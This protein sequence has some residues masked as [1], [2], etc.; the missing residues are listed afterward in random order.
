MSFSH[1][2]PGRAAVCRALACGLLVLSF[3][4]TS[5]IHGSAATRKPNIVV[6][7][8]DDMGWMD[9]GA[10]GSKYYE[11]PNIDR[12]ARRGM[13]FTDAYSANPLCS[14]TRASILTGKYPARHGITTPSGHLPPQ[15]PGYVFMRDRAPP[16]QP[17]LEPESKHYLD[18]AEYTIAEALRDAGY[19]TAHFGK[20][21]LGLTAPY[22]PDK[23]GFDVAWH[24]K[25]DP[26]PP[27]YFSPY[28]FKQY[29]SFA[30][31]P[32]GEYITDRL[33]TEALKFIEANHERP[34]LLHIW[35]YGVH[36]P[37][38]HKEEYT[39][40][41]ADK[42]DARGKQ[43]NPIMASMLKSVDESMGRLLTKLDELKLTDETIILFTSDNG[44]NVHSNTEDD[45]GT[46]RLPPA[47]T[48]KLADWRHWAG[49]Q[50]PTNNAPLRSGKG[51]LYEGGV[52]IPLVVA[53]PGV[54]KVG[55]T[56]S[57]PVSSIDFYPTML[58]MTG[59]VRRPEQVIDGVSLAPLLAG[60]S[61]FKRNALF[62]Y[63]PHSAGNKPAGVT[64][65]RGDWKLIRWWN[66]NSMFPD[67]LE[68][69]NLRDDIGETSN[70]SAKFPELVEE[71]DALIDGFLNSTGATYPKPNPAYNPSAAKRDASLQGW[72]A[73]QC[74]ATVANGVLRVEAI[75][76][77][78]FLGNAQFS[79][80]GPVL[81]KLRARS[82]A[83]GAGKIQ[84]RTTEQEEFPPSGQL[85][86]FELKPG[87]A[88]QDLTV[89]LPVK[90][91]LVHLR[92]YVPA[93]MSPVEIDSLAVLSSDPAS[94]ARQWNFNTPARKQ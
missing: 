19:R 86:A 20:W 13:R 49:N 4:A 16:Q 6:F 87:E 44:G 17:M 40:Q 83:G 2:V 8:V 23:Q 58:E 25:P 56:C 42:R 93:D 76:R 38:G 62:N 82:T 84:W 65:R 15:P 70:L 81:V 72:V 61:G 18:P 60:S 91:E 35:H 33:T 78:P 3:T 64:V 88:W 22:W 31:G 55:S 47:R 7:L 89:E 94:P 26:G 46:K 90:G 39:R 68:L 85:V 45:P 63:F 1:I 52:R 24:G 11:T 43:G 74:K 14:P 27:S 32:P 5:A 69:Y 50:P 36:G 77:T 30:D 29:Q 57:T 10:Y 67:P 21:H 54:A 34:F 37:W 92:L 79:Q 80:A 73:Q 41:F 66:T 75:G 71:L 51:W 12:L 9:C 59:T 53:W 48:Q 28:G